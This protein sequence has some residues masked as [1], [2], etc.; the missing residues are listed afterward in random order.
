[1]KIN[2]FKILLLCA[3]SVSIHFAWAE[4]I[5]PPPDPTQSIVYWKPHT[6]NPEN[7]ANVWLAH[8]IFNNLLRA[9]DNSRVEPSLYVVES[10]NGPW[11]AS[12]ADGNILLS[13][14]AIKTCLNFGIARA[15]HL[16]A[17]VLS[18]ELA[19]QRADD[20]WHQKFFRLVGNQSPELRK[21]LIDDLSIDNKNIVGIEQKEAQADHDGLIMMASVGYDPYQIV[22]KKDFFTTWVENIW[23][24]S[25]NADTR[26]NYLNE[27]CSKA[28][29]RALRTRAQLTTVASQATIYELGIQS[30]IAG[31]FDNAMQYF[32]AYGRDYPS[33]AVYTSLGMTYLAQAQQ[34]QE[35]LNLAV[36]RT[37]PQFYYPMLLDAAPQAEQANINNTQSSTRGNNKALVKKLTRKRDRVITKAIENFEKSI[38]LEPAHKKTYILLAI[39]YLLKENTFMSRGVIQGQYI[40]KFRKDKSAELIIAMTSALEGKSKQALQ[41][42]KKLS[43]NLT[44]KTKTND[45]LP[46]ELLIYTAYYNHAELLNHLNKKETA[47]GLWENLAADA[48]RNGSSVLFRL[49]LQNLGS[50]LS[51][52]SKVKNHPQIAK[53][54]PGDR[55]PSQLKTKNSVSNEIWIEGE[56]LHFYQLE[57]GSK[58]VV[59]DKDKIISAWQTRGNETLIGGI[60]LGD[61]ADRP[62]KTFGLPDRRLN[63]IKGEYLAYDDF[64]LA[65][66][67]LN[68][69]IAGWFLY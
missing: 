4:S 30:F 35:R 13:K 46:I 56:Q 1:M 69:R 22:D 23:S 32:T 47:R 21:K 39:A 68:N 6:I 59:S 8:D 51:L 10:T 38:R 28:Q 42:F 61:K 11:A 65:F 41:Q 18:H 12:L 57:N 55:L 53:L 25:C 31:N 7:D 52:N 15:N 16:L 5:V 50:K 19:H 24:R 49:A 43:H 54:R 27:A 34:I 37:K 64:G 3:Y 26:P 67:I 66:H 48:K 33:R 45:A 2:L 20:L 58:F 63:V 17:F 14:D 9:W 40:P 44:L 36:Q 62:L 29:N 60:K